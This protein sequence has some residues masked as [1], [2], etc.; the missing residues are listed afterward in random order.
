MTGHTVIV[1]IP[2]ELE[3]LAPNSSATGLG[4]EFFVGGDWWQGN[5]LVKV[6]GWGTPNLPS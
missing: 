2:Y 3:E 4:L 5:A 6:L 1:P